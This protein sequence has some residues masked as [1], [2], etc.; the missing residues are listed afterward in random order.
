[1]PTYF[2]RHYLEDLVDRLPIK[3]VIAS[4]V[5]SYHKRFYPEYGPPE[6]ELSPLSPK[7]FLFILNSNPVDSPSFFMPM[8]KPPLENVQFTF[9][10]ESYHR[11]FYPDDKPKELDPSLWKAQIAEYS[12]PC[13]EE[14]ID[15]V[16]TW[17]FDHE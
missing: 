13:K 6:Y 15:H 16:F 14:E 17:R 8:I 4:S 7:D 1:M 2:L 11:W 10:S 12:H 9:F 5:P 3:F